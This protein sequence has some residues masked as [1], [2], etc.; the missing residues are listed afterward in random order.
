MI[1]D[2][3]EKVPGKVLVFIVVVICLW[4]ATVLS[5]A[6]I[7]QK[8]PIEIWGIRLGESPEELR[9]KI[10]DAE[11]EMRKRVPSNLYDEVKTKA[12]R[13]EAKVSEQSIELER[14]R[15]EVGSKEKSLKGEAVDRNL[16]NQLKHEREEL[17]RELAESKKKL[18]EADAALITMREKHEAAVAQVKT[19]TNELKSLRAHQASPF[20]VSVE[21]NYNRI[22]LIEGD[23]IQ[24][25]STI[26]KGSDNTRTVAVP[27]DRPLQLK[28]LGSDNTVSSP[29]A[30]LERMT[31]DDKG[32]YNKVLEV[33]K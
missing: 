22:R 25:A 27:K 5:F 23:K 20:I 13:A 15:R 30:I 1:K 28:I 29:R 33:P 11:D 16:L 7:F 19:L 17:S 8:R 21:G 14:L 2:L 9:K 32:S 10:I 31:V 6:V 24:S 26:I 3:L 18:N 12:S 4:T